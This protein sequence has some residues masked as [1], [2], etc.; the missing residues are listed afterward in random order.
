M[1]MTLAAL[2]GSGK[3]KLVTED[4]TLSSMVQETSERKASKWANEVA[5]A[6]VLDQ[7]SNKT[8]RN[9]LFQNP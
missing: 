9:G 6:Q 5:T 7:A 2:A 3:G 8:T 1:A 4:G